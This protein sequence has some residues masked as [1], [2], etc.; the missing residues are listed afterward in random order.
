MAQTP[1]NRI[2]AAPPASFHVLEPAK[3]ARMNAKTL[4]IP[5][6]GDV[7]RAISAIP[8]GETRTIFELRRE[9]ARTG[10]AETAC[11]AVT[12]KY[13]KWLAAAQDEL[14]GE[15]EYR[16][17]WWRVLKD[18]KPSRHMPGGIEAQT[19]LLREEGVNIR[20]E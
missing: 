7:A 10:N 17:P 5:S 11:P 12:I 3:A 4:Y 13:W 19:A 15:S 18:G 6:V 8:V 1:L 16:I 9:L 20:V 2:R 14:E